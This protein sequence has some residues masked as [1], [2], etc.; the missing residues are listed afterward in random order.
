MARG[1]H[2]EIDPLPPRRGRRRPARLALLAAMTP[3]DPAAAKFSNISIRWGR[4][5]GSATLVS[6]GTAAS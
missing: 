1:A 6:C 3:A 4:P 5:A 2:Q